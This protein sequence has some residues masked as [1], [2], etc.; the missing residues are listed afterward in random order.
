MMSKGALVIF[1]QKLCFFF[2][3]PQQGI[4]NIQCIAQLEKEQEERKEKKS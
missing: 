1:M 4:L 3:N 2:C